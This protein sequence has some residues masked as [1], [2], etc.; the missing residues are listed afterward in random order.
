M[1]KNPRI[2]LTRYELNFLLVRFLKKHGIYKEYMKNRAKALYIKSKSTSLKAKLSELMDYNHVYAPISG[3][4][5]WFGASEG[6]VFWNSYNVK[7]IQ[8]VN[9]VSDIIV[10][11]TSYHCADPIRI[12]LLKRIPLL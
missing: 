3:A 7:W 6:R 1:A 10:D 9:D 8:S 5:I 2:V 12:D 11:V 4:F